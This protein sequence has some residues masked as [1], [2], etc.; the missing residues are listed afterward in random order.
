M[1][2]TNEAVDAD[3]G[4]R[5]VILGVI[6]LCMLAFALVLQ[7]V[8]PVLSLIMADL[9]LSHVQG[10]LLMSFFALPGIIVAIPAGMLADRYSQKTIILVSLGLMI[11]GP[12]LVASGNSFPMLALGRIVSGV[13][14]V[15]F[16]VVAP[17]LLVQWFAG[18]EVGIAM[19]IFNTGMPLGTILSLNLLS[20]LAE[21]LD[22]RASI[23][24][25]AGLSLVAL[26]VFALLFAPA[27]RRS[28]HISPPSEG[29]FQGIRMAGMPIWLLGA[30]W[31]LFNAAVIS[32]FTFTPD[33]LKTAGF[34]IATAGFL[35]S[36]VM[37]PALVLS[38]VVG[39]IIDRIDRKQTIIAVG[40]LALAAL[41]VWVPTAAGG[42]V[43]LMLLIGVAQSLV[44]APIFALP[45][46]VTTP[47]RL[48][49][50]FGIISACL[51][52]GVVVG[53][54]VSGLMKDV[55]GSYQASYALMSGFAVLVAPA[56]LILAR[57]RG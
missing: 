34:S 32:L 41:M 5:W 51:S 24:V 7:S 54:A 14:A 31:G 56:M 13:G 11:V 48:G 55:T 19:G 9:G 35:T 20:R 47:E 44:P 30:A 4:R 1:A 8:P 22:W 57:R 28:E 3:P 21:S 50:G 49:L 53:P 38:P 52:I 45:P 29:F 37:W 18:R 46:D 25:S 16:I 10:G 2:I 26:L 33:L 42:V 23:W 36:L 40:G 39:Y 6:Y 27:P 43:A 12:A 15:T 17:Q